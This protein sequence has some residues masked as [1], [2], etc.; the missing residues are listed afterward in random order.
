MSDACMAMTRRQCCLGLLAAL[1]AP[2]LTSCGTGTSGTSVVSQKK[3]RQLGQEAASEVARTMGLVQDPVLVRYVSEI[4]QRLAAETA[5]PN[6]SYEFHV[7]DDTE[8]N[9]FALPGGF[10]YV[11][12]GI[13]AL[14][15][16]ED[17]LAGVIGHEIGHVVARHSVRR[18]EVSTPLA[19]LFGV[20]SAIAGVVSPALGG[21]IGGVGSLASGLVL[22]PYSREQERE[23]DRIGL[24][25]AAR[26][27]WDP[28]GLPSM[29]HTLEREQA[30]TG[31]DPSR[32]SFFANHPATPDRVK[33]T[34]AAARTLTRRAARPIAGT[35]SAFLARVDGLVVGPDPATGLFVGNTFQHPDLG[36]VVEM[37][38]G[39]KTKNTPATAIAMQPAG[40]AAVALQLVAEGDD[41][42]KGAR[43]D[44][45]DDK[46][47]RQA[48]QRTISGL[49]AVQLV[50]QDRD[51][52][53]HLTWIA[54]QHHVFRV[55]GVSAIRDFE[56]YRETFA[57]T[58]SSFRPLGRDERER[59][60]E[61]RLR[62]RPLR[63][64]ESLAA[65]VARN[66]GVWKVEQTA[67]A[68]GVT[69]DAKLEG[70]FA[71]K[72]PIRQRYEGRRPI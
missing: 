65:F 32:I 37:P 46:L 21:I 39:W 10:V 48:T 55:T 66:G 59:I 44:G 19:L 12:R 24:E 63:A 33:D 15:N 71:V 69:V 22:A 40:R 42:M 47:A 13:L 70:G 61:V 56:S 18:L 4:G 34:T 43:E 6:V 53:L 27:G 25:L 50:G 54:H 60:T 64:D 35:R 30:L 9:A 29:L 26:A 23:A 31:S 68:N 14:A 45:V 7:A 1:A 5:S 58:A 36:F 2:A 3:E 8:P 51:T 49:P 52:R 62:A 11:T 17:E 57:R 28:A 72:V 67:V 20:P 38:A 41:P 16:S